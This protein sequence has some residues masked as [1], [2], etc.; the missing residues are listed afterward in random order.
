MLLTLFEIYY[1]NGLR[2]RMAGNKDCVT[3]LLPESG[4]GPVARTQYG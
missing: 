3:Y 4:V 2:R 1:Q